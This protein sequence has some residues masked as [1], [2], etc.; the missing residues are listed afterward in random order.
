MKVVAGDQPL[1]RHMAVA[2]AILLPVV[3]WWLHARPGALASLVGPCRLLLLTGIPCPTCGATH[4]AA[5]LATGHPLAA[6]ASNPLITLAIL[7]VVV[8]AL[9]G[10]ATSL[11]PRWRRRLVTAP[12]DGRRLAVLAAA[13]MAFNWLWLLTTGRS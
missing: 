2:T 9:L 8:W 13:L 4:A 12:G 1:A 10:V 6:M 11:V 3:G 5:H 7:G